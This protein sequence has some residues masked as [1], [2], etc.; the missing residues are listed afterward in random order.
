MSSFI[1]YTISHSLLSFIFL[2]VIIG[3]VLTILF[4]PFIWSA[5]FVVFMKY[6]QILIPIIVLF[7]G[8]IKL[9]GSKKKE[10]KET[11]F[12]D[13]F[14]LIKKRNI[15][16]CFEFFKLYTSLASG[17]LNSLL[18]IFKLFVIV[19]FGLARMDKP[20]FPRWM[21]ELSYLDIVHQSYLALALFY[22]MYNNPVAITSSVLLCIY[23]FIPHNKIL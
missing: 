18:R 19:V 5:L 20:V 17:L 22:H 16:S 2:V 6:R 12:V 11:F 3:S 13:K 9:F 8:S 15:F 1:G 10:R 7:A 21:L 23:K 14:D 4:W